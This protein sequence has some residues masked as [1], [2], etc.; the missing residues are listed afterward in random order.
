MAFLNWTPDLSVGMN[1]QPRLNEW[2]RVVGIT[3]DSDVL[4]RRLTN[5]RSFIPTPDGDLPQAI[6]VNLAT[7]DMGT[8]ANRDLLDDPDIIVRNP[9]FF[10]FRATLFPSP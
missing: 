2:Y 4:A 10:H 1:F 8:L 3:N 7:A 6:E 5:Q 9:G